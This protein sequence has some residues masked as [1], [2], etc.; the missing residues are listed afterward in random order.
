MILQ[1]N[2]IPFRP[3]TLSQNT[4]IILKDL[5]QSVDKISKHCHPSYDII[6]TVE[7]CEKQLPVICVNGMADKI[8]PQRIMAQA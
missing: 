5:N 4:L 1:Y 7:S 3:K 2:I 8:A 6:T